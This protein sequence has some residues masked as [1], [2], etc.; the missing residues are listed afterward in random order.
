MANLLKLPADWDEVH[1]GRRL[2]DEGVYTVTVAS[3][4]AQSENRVSG[5]LQV[6][7]EG[8]FCGW[9]LY[10]TFCLD[11]DPGKRLFKEFLEAV[12]VA[13]KDGH[14]PLGDCKRKVLQVTVKHK[15]KD[16]QTWANVVRHA[17]DGG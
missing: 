2:I 1:A 8:A 10:E 4:E 16:G 7:D 11:T 14:V 3:L 17:R 6:L 13:P 12:K 9:R 15:T 5:E